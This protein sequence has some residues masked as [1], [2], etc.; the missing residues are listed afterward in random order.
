MFKEITKNLNDL[1]YLVSCFETA[2]DASA[3]LKSKIHDTT[4]GMGGSMTLEE[5]GLYEML[6]GQN[7]VFWHYRL[8]D[9][10]TDPQMRKMAGTASVYLSSV[11][12]IAITGEIVNIDGTGN[13]VASIF[14]GHEKV[15]L[16]AGKNKIAQDYDS[17]LWRARNIAAPL[18]A[19]RLGVKT[20]C[21]VKADRCYNC[22]SPQRICRELSVLWEKPTAA[23]I[24]IILIGEDLGY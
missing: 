11:N 13:R 22:K 17:A 4:V 8:P 7:Q 20:P 21:A 14:Y 23:D 24:E 10:V 19:K 9:G 1:G 2:K 12:A 6:S 3:Y 15:Y 16:V 5:M 18:N